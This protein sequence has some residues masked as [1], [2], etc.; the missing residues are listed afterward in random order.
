MRNS[1]LR[2]AIP[3]DYRLRRKPPK[4][5]IAEQPLRPAGSRLSQPPKFLCPTHVLRRSQ[6][7]FW[8]ADVSPQK[9]FKPQRTQRTQRKF[10]K[11]R[12]LCEL[13]VRFS[14]AAE[15]AACRVR[16]VCVKPKR[17]ATARDPEAFSTTQNV[18]VGTTQIHTL[19]RNAFSILPIFPAQS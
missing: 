18:F 10:L 7:S 2:F 8:I 17:R 4:I 15:T 3:I 5:S 9:N 19:C 13:R 16:R 1:E 12:E 11:L 6:K 14:S